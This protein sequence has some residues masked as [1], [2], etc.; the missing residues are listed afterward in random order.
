MASS[1]STVAV[2]VNCSSTKS[3]VEVALSIRPVAGTGSTV[4]SQVA[5]TSP[6]VA[7]IVA[8]PSA[9]AVT[10]PSST[11]TTSSLSEVQ[12]T[13]L[14]V[15]FSGP[16]TAVSVPVLPMYR[17]IEE[18]LRVTLAA[19]TGATVTSQVASTSPQVAVIV[20][21]PRATAVTTPSSETVAT[22][23]S[24]EVQVRVLSA[25]LSGPTVAVMVAV[26]P[27]L[28]L[29]SV[30]SN[31]IELTST[32]F[33]V[34]SQVAS[35]SPHTT[36]I[37]ATPSPT[38]VSTP[39]TTVTTA[40]SLDVQLRV[41]SVVSSG[42]T[43]AVRVNC[44]STKSSAVVTLRMMPVAGTGST[45][46]SQVAS[47]SPQVAVMLA[48]P[49]AMAVTTPSLTVAT[50]SLS[51]VQTI[52]LSVVFSGPTTAVS[53]PVL[54]T[55]IVIEGA[56][57]VTLAARTG[58]TVTSQVAVRSPHAAAMVAEPRPTAVT[59]P[60]STLATF[61][62]LEVQTTVLS[63]ALAGPTVAVMATYS[64]SLRVASVT[65]SSIELASTGFT[66]T[67][68]VAVASP[69]ATVIVA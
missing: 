29:S 63:A 2:R 42:C 13:V 6:Q 59:T 69:Q 31:A 19:G 51:E 44:S 50:F 28:M 47:T 18:A 68:Q 15:A 36:V 32:G 60:F 7:V 3:S 39:S 46:T 20:A 23:S 53:V 65:S 67:S 64:P 24:L 54:P 61:S 37:V 62:S 38:A 25:A 12:A 30:T 10:T 33:T 21:V 27:S 35:M 48:V 1:G 9:M 56:L 11:V 49:T 5:V 45:V 4:T 52:V 66:V 26:S 41:L 34:T 8:V 43:T 58:S 17:V 16:T 55:A 22:F 40:S 14:S 57:R